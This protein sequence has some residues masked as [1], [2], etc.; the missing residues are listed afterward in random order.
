[1]A[2]PHPRVPLPATIELPGSQRTIQVNHCKMPLCTNFGVPARTEHGKPGPSA[3]RDMRYKVHS[4]SKGTI[5]AIRCKGCLENP[6]I[7]SNALIVREVERLAEAGGIWRLEETTGCG[8]PNCENHNRPIALNPEEYRKRGKPKSRDGQYYQCKRCRRRTL[9][10][11]PVRLHDRNKRLAADILGRIA[12]KSPVRGTIRGSKLNNPQDYYQIV[13]FL[14]RRCRAYSGT[15]D[16]ALIDGRLKLPEDMNIQTDA[17]V[18]QLNWVSRL[19]RRNVELNSYCSVHTESHFVLG[20]HCNFDGRVDPFEINSESAKSGDLALPE[21]F[22]KHG[23]Y[24]L[25]GDELRAG[26][27]M[28]RRDP[29]ARIELLARIEELYGAAATREDVENIELQALNDAYVTP[30]LS[31]G[32]QVHMP[33]TAYAHW[34]L[35]HRILDGAGVKQVQVNSDIDSMTRAA[36]LT[37]YADEV[38]R[39]DAHAFF[40]HSTKF[41]T[42]DERRRILEASKR[43]RAAFRRTLPKALR[44]DRQEV[45]RCMMKARIAERQKHGKWDDEWVVH[46]VPTL[47]EPHKAVCW[48]TPD[49]DLDENR[50]ADVFL[51]SGLARVDNVFLKTRRLFN[52]LERPVGTS[53]G[54]NTVWHGYAPYNPAMLEK[55][56]TIFRAVNNFVFVGEDDKTPAMRLG[57][58]QRP[59]EF[60]DIVWPG[61]R[62]PRPKRSRRRGQKMIAASAVGKVA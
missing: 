39:G 51:R 24:W 44:S 8:D 6:P 36:F 14:H 62:V 32:L 41:Q 31:R 46:P 21:A 16:R 53:S 19:D 35:L 33:Y 60:E 56:V 40:V 15:V 47:N 5:P 2:K 12:N 54:H 48:L 50:K 20:M 28:L 27:A 17:Q 59:L 37:T 58:A 25:A 61:Q 49:P 57:F 30:L 42:I 55:Y 52:A 26:R 7:K 11:D 9:V 45:A 29:R 22:R 23:H 3:D 18:Y 38:K 4:T 43:E 10:S 13:D 1:M 34:F